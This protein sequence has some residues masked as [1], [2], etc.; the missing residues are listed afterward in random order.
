MGKNVLNAQSDKELIT[1]LW[2]GYLLRS[3]AKSWQTCWDQGIYF[4]KEPEDIALRWIHPNSEVIA[5]IASHDFFTLFETAIL[6]DQRVIEA[7]FLADSWLIFVDAIASNQLMPRHPDNYLRWIDLPLH[8]QQQIPDLSWYISR[9]EL[10]DFA[11]SRYPSRLFADLRSTDQPKDDSESLNDDKKIPRM[12]GST[13][14]IVNAWKTLWNRNH[15]E[16][17]NSEVWGY[18][19]S[20]AGHLDSGVA[21]IE[22]SDDEG[23]ERIIF[24]TAEGKLT[25]GTTFKTLQNRIASL[26]GA[27]II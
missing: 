22:T 19:V 11:S 5:E 14:V 8:Q 13:L 21:E 3:F 6:I 25:K 7:F 12:Q 16:P 4:S 27:K 24:D 23:K 18:L 17:S 20:I 9:D 26:K 10:Y 1:E 15:R 2:R